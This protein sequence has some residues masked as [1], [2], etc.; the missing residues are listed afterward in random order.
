METMCAI[1]GKISPFIRAMIESEY[2][3]YEGERAVFDI[4]QLLPDDYMEYL[5]SL[6]YAEQGKFIYEKFESLRQQFATVALL[7]VSMSRIKATVDGAFTS[8][9]VL[10]SFLGIAFALQFFHY[11][12]FCYPQRA[13]PISLK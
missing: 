4:Y 7:C 12:R 8:P 1:S 11:Q 3:G 5:A 13:E 2:S 9:N 10:R 6:S